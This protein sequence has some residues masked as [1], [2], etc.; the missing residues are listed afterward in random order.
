MN[1]QQPN[2]FKTGDYLYTAGPDSADNRDHCNQ[3]M[4]SNGCRTLRFELREREDRMILICHGYVAR[5]DGEQF[6]AVQ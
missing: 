1:I 5:L 4:R 3:L 6:V 2:E